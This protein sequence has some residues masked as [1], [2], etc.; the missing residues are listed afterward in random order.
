MSQIERAFTLSSWL[1][2][3]PKIPP[4]PILAWIAD[5]LWHTKFMG[6]FFGYLDIYFF[7]P[8]SD[9][10]ETFFE[11]SWS[12]NHLGKY[13]GFKFYGLTQLLFSLL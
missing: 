6:P 11:F 3:A 2:G 1:T 7:L 13:H 4:G 8:L 10:D 5:C 12:N 9:M